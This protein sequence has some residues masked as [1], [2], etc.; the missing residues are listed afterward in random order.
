MRTWCKEL[1]YDVDK[2]C[3]YIPA[4]TE[5][6]LYQIWPLATR[7]L[8][9]SYCN[10]DFWFNI[11]KQNLSHIFL[12]FSDKCPPHFRRTPPLPLYVHCT[13]TID[14][15]GPRG[16]TVYSHINVTCISVLYFLIL[17]IIH[18][19]PILSNFLNAWYIFVWFLLNGPDY[20]NYKLHFR[21]C[22]KITQF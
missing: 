19:I 10:R 8:D 12:V 5:T 22:Q 13:L 4:H 3:V 2:M 11:Q 6:W 14:Y 17:D 20:I 7:W 9:I 18:I 1:A 16:N 15:N 21:S